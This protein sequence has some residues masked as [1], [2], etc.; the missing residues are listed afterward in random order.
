M[1]I[2][3]QGNVMDAVKGKTV[4]GV[5]VSLL[6]DKVKAGKGIQSVGSGCF[7]FAKLPPEM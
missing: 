5:K 2:S 1:D 3:L 6:S 4:T 7:V